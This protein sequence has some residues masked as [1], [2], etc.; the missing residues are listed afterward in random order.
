MRIETSNKWVRA[1][2]GDTA[3]VDSRA[4]KLFYEDS[5]PVP[6]YAFS[7]QDVRLD[8]LRPTDEEPPLKPFF[9]LPK[10][11]VREWF[12]V[13]V[14]GRRIRHAAWRRDDPAIADRL[15]FSWQP[16]VLDRW[17]EEEEEV[18]EHPR[19]PHKRVEAIASSRH[20]Q[21]SVD[22]IELA[23]TRRPVLLFETHLPTRFYVPRSDI[24]FEELEPSGNHSRCPYKGSAEEYWSVRD[25]PDA[26][27]VA[28]SY[29]SPFPAVRKVAGMVAFY[30][31]LVDITV[32]GVPQERPVSLF[33]SPANRPTAMV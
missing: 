33:S 8:L 10:G 14:N 24:R 20:I 22:G 11:P 28:W 4:P 32:D 13:E 3:V 31:E 17:M 12:D 25:R 21:I 29:A 15:V 9:Y 1:F 27:N 18:V 6:G 26:A 23:D 16:G 7:D 2:V 5:F 19:D 30:N